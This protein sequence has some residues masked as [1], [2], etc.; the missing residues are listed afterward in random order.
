MFSLMG[1]C[2]SCV[3]RNKQPRRS[4]TLAILGLDSAGKTTVTKAL[5][6]DSLE[7][8]PTVGFS[9]EEITIENYDISLYDL[10]GGRRIREIWTEYLNEVYGII[11]VLDSA[12]P[13]RFPEVKESLENILSHELVSA[14][15]LLV[16]A[17]KDDLNDCVDEVEIMEKLNLEYLVNTHKCVCKLQTCSA[18]KGTGKKMDVNI[19]H[20][21][22]WMC[23][24]L[25]QM[26]DRLKDRVDNDVEVVERKRQKAKEE[27]KE[28]VR[29]VR[30]ERERQQ[31]EER[32]KLGIEKEEEEEED[33]DIVDGANPFKRL[34]SDEIKRKEEKF[35]A[36]KAKDK[37][38]KQKLKEIEEMEKSAQ[39]NPAQTNTNNNNI[40]PGQINSNEDEDGLRAPRSSRSLLGLDW[41]NSGTDNIGLSNGNHRQ[42][43]PPLE[44][45][46][47]SGR[48]EKKKN[49]K[50]KSKLVS[51]GNS[52]AYND[53]DVVVR[54]LDDIANQG[55]SLSSVSRIQV[56]SA[57]NEDDDEDLE[58]LVESSGGRRGFRNSKGMYKQEENGHTEENNQ[59]KKLRK[60]KPKV[61]SDDDDGF[62]TLRLSQHLEDDLVNGL[63]KQSPRT[64]TALTNGVVE[65]ERSITPV[66]KLKKKNKHLRKNKLAPSDDEYELSD[67]QNTPKKKSSVS[68]TSP[69][70]NSHT[71]WGMAENL[72][73]D[74]NRQVRRSRPNFDSEDEPYL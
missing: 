45:P 46:V 33:D 4:I 6:G 61:S 42:M 54:H 47:S 9:K 62:D 29:K 14:K 21:F 26:Y 64:K 69:Q 36:S 52:G 35:K 56:E 41:L 16:L 18:I 40:L 25:D 11:Y 1:N 30:E 10:G 44:S 24:V 55:H 59:K 70:N 49:K 71:N 37:E 50:G 68:Y 60:K 19:K 7:T 38:R 67:V 48:Q 73:A 15:P 72:S 63:S 3:K 17:N 58:S 13:E 8:A 20:G 34:D 23:T 57:P 66:R 43:L 31:E 39:L 27:R 22:K 65:E 2:L 74:D 53:N 12:A 28:R 51:N 32:L 5:L